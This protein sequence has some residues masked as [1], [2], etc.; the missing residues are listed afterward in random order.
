MRIGVLGTGIVGR[1]LATKLVSVGHQVM[2]GSRSAENESAVGWAEE[3][4]QLADHG[5]FAAAAGFGELIVNATS[6]SASLDALVSAEAAN[7]AGKVL[8]DVANPLDFSGGMPPTL[9][10]CNTD[11]LAEQIQGTFPETRVVKTLNT[12]NADVMVNPGVVPGAHTIFV[13]GDDPAAKETVV[14][15]LE[16]LGWP[17]AD[18]MDLGGIEAARGMEMY[19]PLWLRLYGATGTAHVNVKVVPAR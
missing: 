19:L 14:G 10:V 11:S 4:G 8:V 5:N 13:A 3:Q 16:E 9:T 2:M 7:L 12:V 1:T 15:L 18:V 6:G 17:R